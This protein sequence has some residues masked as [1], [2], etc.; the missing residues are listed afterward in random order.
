MD[1][2]DQLEILVGVYTTLI[3]M[4]AR[5]EA[6]HETPFLPPAQ[7]TILPQLLQNHSLKDTSNTPLNGV[8]RCFH[9]YG[10]TDTNES[11]IAPKVCFDIPGL[12]IARVLHKNLKTL[13]IL[14]VDIEGGLLL[15]KGNEIDR[16]GSFRGDDDDD[17]DRFPYGWETKRCE[18][19]ETAKS[20][21]WSN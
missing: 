11:V 14:I 5:S 19:V 1:Y 13:W 17:D 7:A 4:E 3:W 16:C 8:L 21:F 12:P 15:L 10:S 6:T 9:L 18:A 20:P 2:Y